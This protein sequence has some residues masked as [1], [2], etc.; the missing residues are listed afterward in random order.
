MGRDDLA[1]VEARGENIRA[2]LKQILVFIP[3]TAQS[4]SGF[5]DFCGLN[6]STSRRFVKALTESKSGV[7]TAL[8]LPGPDGL[9][10]IGLALNSKLQ[11]PEIERLFVLLVE[12]FQDLILTYARS[13]AE[14]KR[15]LSTLVAQDG[16]SDGD[17]ANEIRKQLFQE[18]ASLIGE[19]V[20]HYLSIHCVSE[21]ELSNNYVSNLVIA[22]CRNVGL[23]HGARPYLQ[24][25]GEHTGP[26]KL[27]EPQFLRGVNYSPLAP[28]QSSEFVLKHFSQSNIEAYYSGI[29]KSGSAI[30]FSPPSNQSNYF[31]FTCGRYEPKYL[32]HPDNSNSLVTSH[33]IVC[34][35]PGKRLTLIVLLANN[36]AK[37]C[38]A[39]S[40]CYPSSVKSDEIIKTNS[41]ARFEQL[42]TGPD[43]R[44]FNPVSH[45]LDKTLRINGVN[46]IL[47]S[48]M[49]LQASALEDYAGYYIDVDYPAWLSTY[50]LG[51][52]F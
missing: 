6:F 52:E 16:Q 15:N 18:N 42:M 34:R 22:G 50:N 13:H 21:N 46:E 19:S 24:S 23:A 44:L 31:S 28:D 7:D 25:F 11:N 26:V 30:V 1:E 41:E 51:F 10:K 14:L 27:S 17:K 48:A 4:I 2:L 5:G 36:L 35:S 29:D 40:G 3:R 9:E 32:S 45:D 39:K 38:L 8:T 43:V 20:E 33:S 49:K 47:R 37:K 12:Q